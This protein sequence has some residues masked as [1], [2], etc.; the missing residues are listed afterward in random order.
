MATFSTFGLKSNFFPSQAEEDLAIPFLAKVLQRRYPLQRRILV[1]GAGQ[2]A[3]GEWNGSRKEVDREKVGEG[4]TGERPDWGGEDRSRA[5]V[6]G[7][8]VGP[9]HHSQPHLSGPDSQPHRHSA[10]SG[11]R[12][13]P[14]R[15]ETGC[16]STPGSPPRRSGRHTPGS[17]RSARPRGC[18]RCPLSHR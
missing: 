13:G 10:V 4:Q 14:A 6:D 12:T 17:R 15:R 5:L 3:S 11:P 7:E 16:R 9:H 18:S 2:V 1:G 8:W